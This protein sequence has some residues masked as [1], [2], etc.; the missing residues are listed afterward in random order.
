MGKKIWSLS[1]SPQQ[2]CRS[3]AQTSVLVHPPLRTQ[4]VVSDAGTWL[5]LPRKLAGPLKYAFLNVSALH[6]L[7]PFKHN[8][9]VKNVRVKPMCNQLLM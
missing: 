2:E 7:V 6:D 5:V 3:P 8:K 9:K 4:Q 1:P